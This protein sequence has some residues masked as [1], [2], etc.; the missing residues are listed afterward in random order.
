VK[1]FGS[2]A[3]F[4]SSLKMAQDMLLEGEKAFARGWLETACAEADTVSE[5]LKKIHQVSGQ[6]REANLRTALQALHGYIDGF[7]FGEKATLPQPLIKVVEKAEQFL[8]Q[9][10]LDAAWKEI[11]QTEKMAADL[12]DDVTNVL[13][14][15]QQ[16]VISG[17]MKETLISMGYAI[18]SSQ[19][20]ENGEKIFLAERKDGA[21]FTIRV[22]RDG[23][24]HFHAEKFPEV[25]E[26][27]L[28]TKR[29]LE[30]LYARGIAANIESEF[31]LAATAERMREVLLEKGYVVQEEPGEG[32]HRVTI[33]A[34]RGKERKK[35]EIGPDSTNEMQVQ[36]QPDGNLDDRA[37]EEEHHRYLLALQD[38]LILKDTEK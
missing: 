28:E 18:K 1:T 38:Q 3:Q 24:F 22:N 23:T 9:G 15:S 14:K 21:K 4:T 20:G 35:L 2:D 19:D 5:Y 30:E 13:Q 10:Q 37:L 7:K 36:P 31:N 25:K 29:L 34:I 26:C 11:N 27:Q 8:N 32:N 12:R 17:G 33:T 16:R 6:L